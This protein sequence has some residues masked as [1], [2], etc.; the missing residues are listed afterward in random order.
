MMALDLGRW[1]LQRGR[2]GDG[3][4]GTG[5]FQD[6][7]FEAECFRGAG[8]AAAAEATARV[9]HWLVHGARGILRTRTVL[10]ARIQYTRTATPDRV[11][12]TETY[13]YDAGRAGIYEAR[14]R[15]GS[16]R[17]V[18]LW[19]LC[20]ELRD[21][22]VDDGRDILRIDRWRGC[23]YVEYTSRLGLCGC[24]MML[25]CMSSE[26]SEGPGGGRIQQ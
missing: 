2:H 15:T 7:R 23:A 21:V 17:G 4:G 18:A 3:T 25:R 16:C 9:E 24:C 14:A 12:G 19:L 26:R 13:V 10:G 8:T 22:M 20:R 6:G 5:R 11:I 1:L